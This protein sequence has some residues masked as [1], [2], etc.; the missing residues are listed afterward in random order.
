MY[1]HGITV[2]LLREDRDRFGDVTLVE[3]GAIAGCAWAPRTRTADTE[4]TDRSAQVSS[5]R[6]LWCPP[7]APVTAH[8][9]VRF[10]D[11]T[12]WQVRGEPDDWRSPYTGWNPGLQMELERVTG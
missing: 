7:G 6:T 4:E 5:G 9:R 8:H 2:T 3:D 11:G 10:P 1:P 12:V